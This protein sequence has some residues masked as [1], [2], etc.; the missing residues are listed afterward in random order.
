MK[1]Y[2]FPLIL[3]VFTYFLGALLYE[4]IKIHFIKEVTTTILKLVLGI[5]FYIYT[6]KFIKNRKKIFELSQIRKNEIQLILFLVILFI[7]NNYF[8]LT[9]SS[10]TEYMKT[11][12]IGLIILNYILNSF[13][14]EFAYRGFIQ[15]YVNQ[16]TEK[17]RI[18]ISQGNL[19]AS[20]L[21]IFP[22]LGFFIVMD[23]TFAVTGIILVF[24]YSLFAIII[25]ILIFKRILDKKKEKFEKRDN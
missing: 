18:P 2:L 1:K 4:Q 13:F 17:L 10:N 14:E 15:N 3:F 6:I 19:F 7:T 20:I 21:M 11:Q 23:I 9:Y 5:S 12:V 8:H 16:N 24:I 25:V 22:H